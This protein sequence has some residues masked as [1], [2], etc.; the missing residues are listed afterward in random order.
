MR[1]AAM[2]TLRIVCTP[3]KTVRPIYSPA[4]IEEH[5]RLRAQQEEIRKRDEAERVA[6]REQRA[7]Q[8][9]KRAAIDAMADHSTRH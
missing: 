1:K 9:A 2:P 8:A 3:V 4:A 6:R 5:K 7:L